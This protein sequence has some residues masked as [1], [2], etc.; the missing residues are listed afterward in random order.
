MKLCPITDL[1]SE[2]RELPI[3]GMVEYMVRDRAARMLKRLCNG[4][5]LHAKLYGKTPEC[6]NRDTQLR[7]RRELLPGMATKPALTANFTKGAGPGPLRL[8]SDILA[9]QRQWRS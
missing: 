3:A 5:P 2:P 8:V 6:G 1:G 9:T 7:F 4:T